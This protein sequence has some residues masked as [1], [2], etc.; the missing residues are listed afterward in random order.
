MYY[1][2]LVLYPIMKRVYPYF[3]S[4]YEYCEE[5]LVYS[6]CSRGCVQF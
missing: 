6:F 4:G 5:I 1:Y 3:L 2:V